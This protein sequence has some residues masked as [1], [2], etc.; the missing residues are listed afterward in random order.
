MATQSPC[1]LRTVPKAA[2]DG[3]K[4]EWG[5]CCNFSPWEA[6][7]GDDYELC[8]RGA[9]HILVVSLVPGA[10]SGVQ[11]GCTPGSVWAPLTTETKALGVQCSQKEVSDS[12]LPVCWTKS[13][14][15]VW[16][17]RGSHN[18]FNYCF[19]S[20]SVISLRPERHKP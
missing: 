9:Q 1:S 18:Y 5:G 19:Y 13:F 12:E 7:V 11:M 14:R 6:M 15:K 20:G 17:F 4:G 10:R 2:Q 8:A 16:Q 3:S